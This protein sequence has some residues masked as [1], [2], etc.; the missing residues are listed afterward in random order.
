MLA[1]LHPY[2]FPSLC[3]YQCLSS[4]SV[5]PLQTMCDYLIHPSEISGYT[6]GFQHGFGDTNMR[7]LGPRASLRDC[8]KAGACRYIY[9]PWPN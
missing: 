9:D 5:S 4:F 6:T 2:D 8:L 1:S 7:T 3:H